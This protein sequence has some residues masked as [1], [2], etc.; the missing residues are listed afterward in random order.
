MGAIVAQSDQQAI[1]MGQMLGQRFNTLMFSSMM[2]TMAQGMTEMQAGM[3]E[4]QVSLQC[5]VPTLDARLLGGS[6]DRPL[7]L[8]GDDD[9]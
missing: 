8:E 7:A 2:G 5:S 4:L 3:E 1:A 6:P 9:A